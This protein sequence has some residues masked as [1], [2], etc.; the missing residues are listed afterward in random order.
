MDISVDQTIVKCDSTLIP[1]ITSNN[2]DYMI[3]NNVVTG[4]TSMQCTTPN[5]SVTEEITIPKAKAILFASAN[6]A[7]ADPQHAHASVKHISGSTFT[8]SFNRKDTTSTGVTWMAV[9]K[10]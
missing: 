5:V 2:V 10:Y 8:L 6:V 4:T 3:G 9:V 7:T 1:T